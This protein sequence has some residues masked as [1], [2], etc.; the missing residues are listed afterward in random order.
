MGRARRHAKKKSSAKYK[1]RWKEIKRFVRK[2]SNCRYSSESCS[3]GPVRKGKKEEVYKA[4]LT[5]R[6]GELQLAGLNSLIYGC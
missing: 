1:K 5:G 6:G 2:G 4:S 3:K